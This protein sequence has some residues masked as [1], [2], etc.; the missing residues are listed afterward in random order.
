MRR[1]P[2]GRV[3]VLGLAILCIGS[4]VPAC[5]GSRSDAQQRPTVIMISFD[6]TRPDDLIQGRIPSLSGLAARGAA[7]ERLVPSFPS[8]TFPNHV[9]LV[10]G[11]APERHGVVDNTFVD[12][13]RGL[14]EKQD[15]PSWIEIE[16]IWSLLAGA[17]IASA[18]FHW[19]GSEGAWPSGGGPRYWKPFSSRTKEGEKVEQIL[20][21]LDLPPGER[22]HLITSWFHGAD[23]ESHLH[24]PDS[25]QVVHSL[26]AQDRAFQVLLDGIA[27]RSLWPTTTVLVVSD[28]GMMVPA[29]RVDLGAALR[30]A[31]IVGRVIGIGGFASVRVRD[32]DEDRAIEIARTLGLSA[33]RREDAPAELRVGNPRFGPLVVVAPRGTAIVYEGLVLTGFHGHRPEVVEMAAIFIAAGR[34]ISPGTQL[35]AVRNVD[36]APTVLR[37]LGVAVPEWMEGRPLAGLV[38][39]EGS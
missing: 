2:L 13:E 8:N 10:T 12:P 32:A 3:I 30:E 25:E 33:W 21:W 28:H 1:I 18:S 38:D 36:V 31:G 15:I 6:G 20:A 7:A 35:P 22:P 24:G 5:A 11:V 39:L 16:P 9:T 34:G 29:N 14:F 19:V 23:H 37:L 26:A 17:G 4:S 27:E